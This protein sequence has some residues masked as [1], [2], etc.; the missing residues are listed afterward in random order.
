MPPLLLL[1]RY[2]LSELPD[3]CAL[4]DVCAAGVT[5]EN[6]VLV[7]SLVELITIFQ[8]VGTVLV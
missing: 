5:P 7:P 3:V 1:L 6:T 4:I 8:K 2:K